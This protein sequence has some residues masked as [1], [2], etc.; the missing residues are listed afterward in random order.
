[1]QKHSRISTGDD[2]SNSSYKFLKYLK[3]LVSGE[4][5]SPKKNRSSTAAASSSAD[6]NPETPTKALLEKYMN[7][8]NKTPTR[9][10][11]RV[12][13]LGSNSP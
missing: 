10:F 5:L 12:V 9:V 1:M 4:A 3:G 8:L 13:F 6:S 2:G 7:A 11:L